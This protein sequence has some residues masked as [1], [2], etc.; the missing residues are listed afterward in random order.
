M[1]GYPPPPVAASVWKATVDARGVTYYFNSATNVTQWEKPEELK[2]DV[3]VSSYLHLT[4]TLR[5]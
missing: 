2:D 1:N 3:D 4:H 5:H